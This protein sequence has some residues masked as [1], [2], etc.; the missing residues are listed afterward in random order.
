MAETLSRRESPF[1]LDIFGA[2][3]I[4]GR[5]ANEDHYRYDDQLGLLAVGH[6][7]SDR[8]ASCVA[9]ETA[10]EALFKYMT[11]PNVTSPADPRERMER[12]FAHV[13]R[14]I[15]EQA[16][17]DTQLHGMATTLACAMEK[18]RLLL[19]GHVGDEHV[20]RIRDGRLERLTLAP[21]RATAPLVLGRSPPGGTVGSAVPSALTRAMGLGETVAPDVCVE[22]LRAD[23]RV[24]IATAGLWAVVDDATILATVQCG[25]RA[26]SI[27]GELVQCALSR[28]APENVTAV[29]AHWRAPGA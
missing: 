13:H 27:V 20:S 25:R 18:G 17:T 4:G 2:S 28:G 5:R 10:I 15:R 14:R 11:D 1:H 24:L 26:C 19:V 23:D 21:R 12:A 29:Y 3:H 6:G 7:L 8:P 16:A 22:V 9:A